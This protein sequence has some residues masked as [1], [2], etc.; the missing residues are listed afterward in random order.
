MNTV[1]IKFVIMALAKM[2]D[3][4][5]FL[6]VKNEAYRL[7]YTVTELKKLVKECRD[8]LKLQQKQEARGKR[9]DNPILSAGTPLLSARE[10]I[11]RHQTYDGFTTIHHRAGDFFGWEHTHYRTVPSDEIRS[12]LY[13]FFDKAKTETADGFAPFNPNRAKVMD[14]LDALAGETQ[15]PAAILAPGWLDGRSSPDPANILPCLNGLLDVSE[16]RLFEHTPA[17]FGLTALDFAYHPAAPAPCAWAQFLAEIWPDDLES[18]EALQ[19]IFG[20]LLTT[21]TCH[22]KAFLM[23]GPKRSGKGT[24]ARVL[25]ALLGRDNVAGPTLNGLAG[26]FGLEPILDKPLAIVSDARLSGKIDQQVVVERLLAITGE[27]RLTVERKHRLAWTGRLPTRFLLLSNE[28]PRLADV[29]GAL[30][31]RFIV[32]T[33]TQSFYGKEDHGLTGRLLEELPGILNWALDGLARLR[34]RG[35]LLQP[36]SA[37]EAISEL[38]DLASPLGAF[39]RDC[40]TLQSGCSVRCADLYAAWCEWCSTQGRDHPGTT[41]SFARDLRSALPRLKIVKPRSWDGKS[42]RYFEGIGL[43]L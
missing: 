29:S 3:D 35:R 39:L 14:A 20:L 36:A 10:Y 31:S 9:Q 21:D 23:V 30:A 12:R 26:P 13:H 43:L 33:M 32:L 18:I 11:E 24:I 15:L 16:R 34:A 6:A 22:Q 19:E 5:Y 25:T 4:E 17:F 1:D 42:I 28:L 2:P 7:G 8:Q 27:D 37:Q 41:Q 40:C 38:E